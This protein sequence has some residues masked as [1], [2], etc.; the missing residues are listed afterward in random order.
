MV[1]RHKP[2]FRRRMKSPPKWK[3][4]ILVWVCIYPSVTSLFLI[5]GDQLALLPPML[6][7]LVLTLV[8]VPLLVFVLLPLMHKLFAGW[9]HR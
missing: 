1:D 7:T 6:R 3:T 8:L 4:A 9:L 2:D 5:F